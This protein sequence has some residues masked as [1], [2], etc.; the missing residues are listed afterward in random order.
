MVTKFLGMYIDNCLKWDKHIQKM[1]QKISQSMYTIIRARSILTRENLM[2]LYYSMVY[3]YLSYGIALW[4]G[5]YKVHT[6]QLAKENYQ[7]YQNV[8]INS[9]TTLLFKKK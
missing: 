8:P 7:N 3:P 1:K 2:T 9:H 6:S 5:S 4:G